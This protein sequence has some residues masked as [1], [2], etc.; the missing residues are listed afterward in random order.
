[1][2]QPRKVKGGPG[3]GNANPSE[4]VA[5]SVCRFKEGDRKPSAQAQCT[6]MEGAPVGRVFQHPDAGLEQRQKLLL[7][8]WG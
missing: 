5:P 1:M 6:V 7:H 4:S 2:I 3:S 8:D